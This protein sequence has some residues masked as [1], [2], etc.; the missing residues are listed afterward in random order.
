MALDDELQGIGRGYAFSDYALEKLKP[1]KE[2]EQAKAI[3]GAAAHS[4]DENIPQDVIMNE[5]PDRT[6]SGADAIRKDAIEKAYEAVKTNVKGIIR[7]IEDE[8]ELQKLA[9]GVKPVTDSA[10]AQTS[11]KA[12]EGIEKVLGDDGKPSREKY[13]ELFGDT[14]LRRWLEESEASTQRVAESYVTGRTIEI[15]SQFVEGE[16]G[17]INYDKVIDYIATE[18]SA[19]TRGEVDYETKEVGAKILAAALPKPKEEN[20]EEPSE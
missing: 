14:N 8:S 16:D 6:L 18:F 5:D 3:A 10:F 11:R 20:K 12:K 2:V 7:E 17:K 19:S 4:L 1:I 9:I 13:L 15:I